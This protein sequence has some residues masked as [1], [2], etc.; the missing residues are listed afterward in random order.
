M[1]LPSSFKK[2]LST[3]MAAFPPQ[4]G[5]SRISQFCRNGLD[6]SA[7]PGSLLGGPL[8]VP[9]IPAVF[10]QIDS[11]NALQCERKLH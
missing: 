8:I 4:F 6:S 7:V 11:T 2:L 5:L 10:F 9:A 1:F 3:K